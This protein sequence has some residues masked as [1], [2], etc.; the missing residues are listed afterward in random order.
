[1]IGLLKVVTY[2]EAGTEL[3]AAIGIHQ[4][5]QRA[6]AMVAAGSPAI[7]FSIVSAKDA[8]YMS[9]L[10]LRD[11]RKISSIVKAVEDG[12]Y[13]PALKARMQERQAR[14]AQV[15]EVLSSAVNPPP[16]L[17]HPNLAKLCERKVR[18]LEKAW[19][20]LGSTWMRKRR[21]NSS[22]ANETSK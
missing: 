3:P 13:K 1:V 19:K 18:E 17:I 14:R 5:P 15:E 2:G 22:Q 11:T 12:I 6:A 16:L 10:R 4:H 8:K 21:M 20:P 9:F 7:S